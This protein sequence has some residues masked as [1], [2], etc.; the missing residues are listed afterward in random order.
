L[1]KLKAAETAAYRAKA[2]ADQGGVCALCGTPMTLK[3]PAVLDHDHTTGKVRG[4]LHR[5]CN[6][7]LGHIE[8]NGPRY[9]L[10]D[11]ARLARFLSKLVTYQHNDVHDVMYP[12]HK[13]EDEKRLLRNKRAAVARKA[14]KAT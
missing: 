10:T 3:N 4:V 9:F 13:T 5:G 8:N 1:R 7:M 2:L 12:T 6:S 11:V 14:R